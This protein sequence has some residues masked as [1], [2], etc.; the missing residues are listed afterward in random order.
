MRFQVTFDHGVVWDF[1][2]EGEAESFL[3]SVA[4]M[5]GLSQ[6]EG[7]ADRCIHFEVMSREPGTFFGPRLL[8]YLRRLPAEEW[9]IRE[10]HNMVFFQHP[11]VREVICETDSEEELPLRVYQMRRSL[12]PVYIDA[13]LT[14][15]LPV[16]GALVEIEGSGVIL[17]GSS[18]AGKSTTSRRFPPPWSVLGDDLCL[19]VR[20]ASG[21]YRVHP[22]PTWS[23]F[24]GN[25]GSGV[26][27]SGLS[28]PL[29]AVFFLAQ[30]QEDCCLD[31]KR[32]ITALSLSRSALE[33]FRSID[34]EF[35]RREEASVKKA[36]YE[37]AASIAMATP[38]YHLCLS[39]T[40]RFWEKIEE[41]LERVKQSRGE[42]NLNTGVGIDAMG[43]AQGQCFSC[44][45]VK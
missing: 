39:L 42:V 11:A 25:G 24:G 22:L 26:C 36:L 20:G 32:S 8:Q 43:L 38:A 27:H 7:G 44:E 16:H 33:V 45:D 21:E 4:L 3:E 23:A 9:K 17:A 18:G 19:V 6:A 5:M 29:R 34:F 2:A 1:E 28:V 37:S 35:P 12:L 14:G 10:F 40:G 30:S 13:M 41:V 31:L 15:G